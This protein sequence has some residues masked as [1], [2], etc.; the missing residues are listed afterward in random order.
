MDHESKVK[1]A[2][3]IGRIL[4]EK[5]GKDILYGFLSGS[6]ARGEDTELSDLEVVFVTKEKIRIP[7][8]SSDG[9]REFMYKDLQVQIEFRA[10]NETE[11]AVVAVGPYW[12]IEVAYFLNPRIILG[13]KESAQALASVFRKRVDNLPDSTFQR[14][15]GHSLLWIRESFHKVLNAC[16]E[17]DEI[18][19]VQSASGMCD[20]A[21]KFV[22]LVNGRYYYRADARMSEESKSFSVL[23]SDFHLLLKKLTL[24]RG[25][26][27][28]R[29]TATGLWSTCKALA[30]SEEVVI[31]S[32]E[33]L[34][35]LKLE[36]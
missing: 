36:Q 29:A 13:D 22:A 6:V 2:E 20:E 30:G 18:R 25:I 34:K 24:A 10:K 7:G 35:N 16:D 3:E 14:A 4:G 32:Y 9:Y 15:A 21:A 1:V 28:I 8:M 31:E 11:E 27:E 23:P 19:A 17:E 12:P 26:D 5:F 33:S